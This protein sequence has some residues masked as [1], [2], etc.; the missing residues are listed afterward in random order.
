M[1]S[2]K[3]IQLIIIICGFLKLRIYLNYGTVGVLKRCDTLWFPGNTILYRWHKSFTIGFRTVSF[4]LAPSWAILGIISSKDVFACIA[5]PFDKICLHHI[6]AL[7]TDTRPLLGRK[8][9]LEV[10]SYQ[11]YQC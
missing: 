11:K 10:H 7:H 6:I 4:F 2:N 5:W 8:S 1:E 9:E 3:C